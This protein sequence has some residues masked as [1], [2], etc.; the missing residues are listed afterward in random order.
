LGRCMAL[1]VPL[2]GNQSPH[3]QGIDACMTKDGSKTYD[4]VTMKIGLT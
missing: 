1:W 2:K 3:E 4:A